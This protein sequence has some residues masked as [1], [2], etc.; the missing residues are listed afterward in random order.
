MPNIIVFSLRLRAAAWQLLLASLF[1]LHRQVWTEE[2][3]SAS[4]G[5]QFGGN[6][7]FIGLFIGFI[8]YRIAQGGGAVPHS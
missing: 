1:A 8:T 6:Q 4:N 5:C 2:R 7:A 3:E